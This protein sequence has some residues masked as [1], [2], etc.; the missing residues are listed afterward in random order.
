M[1]LSTISAGFHRCGVFP[2]NL[3]AIDCGPSVAR[4][5][6]G[7]AKGGPAEESDRCQ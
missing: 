6:P 5:D 1:A 3:S 4:T 2:F 7:V